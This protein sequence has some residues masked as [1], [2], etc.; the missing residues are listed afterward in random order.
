[1]LKSHNKH[2]KSKSTQKHYRKQ[3]SRKITQK[4]IKKD[5]LDITKIHHNAHHQI[6][7]SYKDPIR[8]HQ[9]FLQQQ[10]EIA[11]KYTNIDKWVN[12]KVLN[13]E[14]S[15]DLCENKQITNSQITQLLKFRTN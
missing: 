5:K 12:N 8:N 9:K 14:D 4:R 6:G 7:Y 15:N 1:M 11:K 2:T 10:K 3:R 13:L